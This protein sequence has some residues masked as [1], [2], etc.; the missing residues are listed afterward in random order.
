MHKYKCNDWQE[1]INGKYVK[2][3]QNLPLKHKVKKIETK[4]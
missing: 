4:I 2:Q 1:G 3:N